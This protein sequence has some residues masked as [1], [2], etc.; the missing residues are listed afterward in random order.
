MADSPPQHIWTAD[1]K[2]NPTYFNQ[3]VYD[4]S[5]FSSEHLVREGWLAIVHPHDKER[6]IKELG[7]VDLVIENKEKLIIIEMKID[8]G[9]QE[10]QLKRYSDYGKRTCKEYKIY[11]LTLFGTD[12]SM[13][14]TGSDEDIEYTRISFAS[15]ILHWLDACIRSYN[16]PFLTSIRESLRQYSKLVKKITNQVD[17]GIAMDIKN[18]LLKDGNL[19]IIDEVTKAIPYAKAEVQFI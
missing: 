5:G 18:F 7:R 14:S 12:A 1:P 17:G 9:E 15:D 3:S 4:F 13:Y 8:A 19:E 16:T 2:G 11:Y 10:E 6:N